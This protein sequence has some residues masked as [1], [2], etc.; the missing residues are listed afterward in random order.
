MMS[1]QAT[2]FGTGL[3][4]VSG[5]PDTKHLGGALPQIVAIIP[6]KGPSGEC[7]G[8]TMTGMNIWI[9]T[10]NIVCGPVVNDKIRK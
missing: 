6:I 3:L 8:G 4:N 2:V 1:C 5:N 9:R 7:G 10:I